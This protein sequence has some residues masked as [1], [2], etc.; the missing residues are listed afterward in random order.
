MQAA[1]E[2]KIQCR[3]EKRKIQAT[4]L[5]VGVNFFFLNQKVMFFLTFFPCIPFSKNYDRGVP[6]NVPGVVWGLF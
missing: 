2:I 3:T 6:Q 4:I 1:R 5:F